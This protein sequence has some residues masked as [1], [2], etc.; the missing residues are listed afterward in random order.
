[1]TQLLAQINFITKLF[2]NLYIADLFDVLIIASL[3][4][5]IIF[6]F[7]QT[8]SFYVAAGF[9]I[10][11]ALYPIAQTF[12]LYLTSIVFQAFW[13][14]FFIALVVIFQEELRRF[15]EQLALWSTR[16]IKGDKEVVGPTII[17]DIL[18]AVGK[19]AMD[20]IG[21]LIVLQGHDPITKFIN[22][23]RIL[24]GV[25]S[26]ELL[27]SLFDPASMGHDGALVIN[28]NRASIFG[29][30]LPLSHDFAQIGKRGTRH[31]AALGLS[32]VSDA[33]VIVVSE[34]R[35]EVSYVYRGV[36][37][38]LS[39]A[40][41]LSEPLGHFLSDTFP[42]QNYS[43]TKSFVKYNSPE[44]MVSLTLAIIFWFF[45]S[46]QAGTIQRVFNIPITYE[47][48]GENIFIEKTEPDSATVMLETRGLHSFDL[49]DE[50][51][52]SIVI[53]AS[54]LKPGIQNVTITDDKMLVPKNFSIINID[55]HDIKVSAKSVK[56][57][58]MKVIPII[59][60]NISSGYQIKEITVNPQNVDVL[61]PE[62]YNGKNFL[63]TEAITILGSDSTTTI[64]KLVVPTGL[65]L[66]NTSDGMI[67]VKFEIKKSY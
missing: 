10:I 16:Q 66:K 67:E 36:F 65:K 60:N 44:K 29:G 52:L 33:F 20:K 24:D 40:K 22:G 50:K 46:F 28:G 14:V 11:I 49:L 9:G 25:V 7:K 48:T 39:K 55:P 58:N 51:S 18:D 41:E 59:I 45:F 34:E 13:S 54:K 42:K 27:L 1:M 64:S 37:K 2:S 8:R 63:N 38:T 4:Y 31:S 23:G 15:F 12:G 47:N 21:A 26:E 6:L 19:M 62:T 17:K 35:G 57:I 61:A 32:E 30:H 56:N 3:I 43:T 53:D 5:F